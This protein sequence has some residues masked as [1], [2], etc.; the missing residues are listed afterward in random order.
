MLLGLFTSPNV[1][2]WAILQGLLYLDDD[3][4]FHIPCLAD[5]KV[6]V[7]K[8]KWLFNNANDRENAMSI[9][10]DDNIGDKV[11]I[12]NEGLDHRARCKHIEHN[13]YK[14]TYA[15]LWVEGMAFATRGILPLS[16]WD[17]LLV[18]HDMWMHSFH[19]FSVNYLR[20]PSS[21]L[22]W[23]CS[24]L[25]ILLILMVHFFSVTVFLLPLLHW[26]IILS[27]WRQ[28]C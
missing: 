17:W 19:E 3:M 26:I 24:C 8:H 22:F 12:I 13:H 27:L 1:W 4:M 7:C 21:V 5:C 23:I 14:A 18:P 15:F 20:L 6:I 10:H 16:L 28:A 2:F 9:D 25:A 11:V